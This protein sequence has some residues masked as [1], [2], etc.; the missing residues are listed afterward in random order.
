MENDDQVRAE[1]QDRGLW[2]QFLSARD[3]RPGGK[4]RSWLLATR[5]EVFVGFDGFTNP[6][7]NGFVWYRRLDRRMRRAV[8]RVFHKNSVPAE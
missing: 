8:I 5:R 7:D 2:E 6:A 3:Q 1:L 4:P